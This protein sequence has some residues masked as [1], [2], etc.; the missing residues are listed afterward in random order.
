[1][2]TA[3]PLTLLA[4]A[5]AVLCATGARPARRIYHRA[6]ARRGGTPWVIGV[7]LAATA[8]VLLR[9]VT[10][11]IAALMAAATIGYVLRDMHRRRRRQRAAAAA[12]QCAGV[13]AASIRA[14]ASLQ[15][16]LATAADAVSS[17]P[18]T[19]PLAA[20]VNRIRSGRSPAPA[21]IGATEA[22]E[23]TRIGALWQLS[24]HHGIGLAS[25]LER[26]Q[27]QLDQAQ[28]HDSSVQAALQGPMAT[29]VILSLLPALG[30]GLGSLMGAAPLAFLSGTSLG[31][32]LLL[33][34]TALIC[35][36]VLWTYS[37]IN[38][39]RGCPSS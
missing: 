36:G 22:P 28:R 15:H 21:L 27:Q 35:G 13:C 16:A 10:L 18:I 34:G 14:G 38:K 4:L 31:G 24:E 32:V 30:V 5:G 29:A 20:A 25:L 1:M 3:P 8:I 19:H 23:L 12:G 26:T 6:T 17:T 33:V 7:M 39:A 9:A 11:S 37:I 2:I